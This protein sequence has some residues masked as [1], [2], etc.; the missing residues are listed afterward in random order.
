MTHSVDFLPVNPYSTCLSTFARLSA[1]T[2]LTRLAGRTSLHD[3]N[4]VGVECALKDDAAPGSSASSLAALANRI[5]AS[6]TVTTL[7]D[8]SSTL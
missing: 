7:E 6:T 8:D 5:T 1:V 4:V 2:S 3:F